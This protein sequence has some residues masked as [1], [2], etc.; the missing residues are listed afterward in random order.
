MT[1]RARPSTGKRRGGSGA[2]N[3]ATNKQRLFESSTEERSPDR[4]AIIAVIESPEWD[5]DDDEDID[6]EIREVVGDGTEEHEE[7]EDYLEEE[8]GEDE[9]MGIVRVLPS[10][11]EEEMMIR[12]RN[13]VVDSLPQVYDYTPFFNSYDFLYFFTCENS[14]RIYIENIT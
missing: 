2:A 14:S 10:T 9:G 13:S 7:D 12:A 4:S 5:E 11:S 8:S 6:K 1:R 3:G